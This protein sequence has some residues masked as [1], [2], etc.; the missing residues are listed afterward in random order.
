[1][2]PYFKTCAVWLM[3]LDASV[4]FQD[5][6]KNIVTSDVQFIVSA[7]PFVHVIVF[8]LRYVP[9]HVL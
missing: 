7:D 1:M 9:P 2:R 3:M 5:R 8:V 6:N 4:A